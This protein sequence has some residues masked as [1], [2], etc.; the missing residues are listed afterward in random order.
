MPATTIVGLL[1]YGGFIFRMQTRTTTIPA[2]IVLC[3]GLGFRF[4]INR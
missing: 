4:R 1:V 2:E 3:F